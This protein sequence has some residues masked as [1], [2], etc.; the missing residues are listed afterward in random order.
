[1]DA[2]LRRALTE[3]LGAGCV[4]HDGSLL[5]PGSAEGVAAV[6]RIAQA[7][8]LRLR[9]SSGSGT[10]VTGADGVTVLSLGGL[11]ALGVDVRRGIVRAEAGAT[12]AA[13]GAALAG[14][15][16]AVPGL[17][18]HPGAEH[19][20]ELIARG[21]LPRRSLT[22]I[23]AVLPGGE[24]IMAGAAVLKDVVGYDVTSLLLG[25]RGRLAAIVAAHL[26]LVPAAVAVEVAGPAGARSVEELAAV[27]DPEGLLAEG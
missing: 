14:A 20:G 2:S 7:H 11:T 4:L 19:V 1:V 6:L 5:V 12:L 16:M 22:G 25:S 23:E 10:G 21:E 24:P 9:I 26:R 15:G 8:R 3:A 18:A 27:F 17:V 13:L